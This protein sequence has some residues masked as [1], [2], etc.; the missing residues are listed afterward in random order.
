MRTNDIVFF[1][2]F[3]YPKRK[4]E[5]VLALK[6]TEIAIVQLRENE[7]NVGLFLEFETE[8]C[9]VVLDR[10][11]QRVSTMFPVK[12]KSREDETLFRSPNIVKSRRGT[13]KRVAYGDGH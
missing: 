3:V 10:P 13:K 6:T 9:L 1:A 12:R 4:F 8:L 11:L 2:S 5:F 7:H